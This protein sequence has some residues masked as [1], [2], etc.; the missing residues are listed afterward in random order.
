MPAQDTL[1][2]AAGTAHEAPAASVPAAPATPNVF[3]EGFVLLG[4]HHSIDFMPF[5][6]LS[7][8]YMFF[9][10]GSFHYF[11]NEETLSA[12]GQYIGDNRAENSPIGEKGAAVRNDGKFTPVG[13]DLSITSNLVFLLLVTL[14]TFFVVGC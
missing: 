3:G 1:T 5:G 6:K 14:I 10:N 4:N 12:S 11:S 8:P 2:Q 7:L 13:L 9:D